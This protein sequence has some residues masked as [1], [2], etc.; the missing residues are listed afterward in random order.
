M[1]ASD[2]RLLE[3][4]EEEGW[5]TVRSLGRALDLPMGVTRDRVRRLADAELVAFM[6]EDCELVHLTA[7]GARYLAGD[8]DQA[9]HPHPHPLDVGRA[10]FGVLG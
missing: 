2:E 4:L 7:D 3:R 8:R 10:T 5:S 9:L 1:L 6:T